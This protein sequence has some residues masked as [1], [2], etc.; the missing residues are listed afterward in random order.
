MAL[1][2]RLAS[3]RFLMLGCLIVLLGCA[4]PAPEE[5]T[6]K[7][8]RSYPLQYAEGFSILEYESYW[9][10]NVHEAFP[11]ADTL[12]YRIA[13][14]NQPQYLPMEADR[15]I[16][17]STTH[18]PAL[19]MLNE[20]TSLVGFPGTQYISTTEFQPLIQSEAITDLG[21]DQQL[22]VEKI[23][24]LEPAWVMAFSQGNDGKQLN[25]LRQMGVPVILNGDYMEKTVLGRA[26]WIKFMAVFFN[27]LELADRLFSQIE[28]TYNQLRAKADKA[29][30]RPSV[31][32]GLLYGDRW[33][34]PGGANWSAT[35]IEDAGGA[36]IWSSN[37]DRGWLELSYETVLDAAGKSDYWIG[38]GSITTMQELK[39]A[40]A[41]YEQFKPFQT[42]RVY[43]YAGRI[44][45]GGGV[46]YLE[47]GYARPDIVLK[48]LVKILHPDLIP[49]HNLYFFMPLS[50]G[51]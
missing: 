34:V 1:F 44:G 11:G 16:C 7:L 2:A 17:T 12:S 25:K 46:D 26:E 30:N 31:M 35:L 13:K 38:V 8:I 32:K 28:T 39:A 37:T 15:V 9:Q 10:I 49:D 14:N 18:L 5:K 3:M 21:Q 45:P 22:N 40:D 36:Y 48:D 41:R 43:S 42:G 23:A 47:N 6:E 51:S 24:S 19:A 29:S 27:K 33:F 20:A 50:N 4:Q